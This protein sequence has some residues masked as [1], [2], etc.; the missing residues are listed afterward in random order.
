LGDILEKNAPKSLG[1]YFSE[2]NEPTAICTISPKCPNFAQSGRTAERG[3][4]R[5]RGMD[6]EM[7]S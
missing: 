5:F 1:K 4:V 6:D 3:V 2:K 7:E